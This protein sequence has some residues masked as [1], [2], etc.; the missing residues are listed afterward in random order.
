ME[1][2]DNQFIETI[3]KLRNNFSSIS[4]PRLSSSPSVIASKDHH[5]STNSKI[6]EKRPESIN[7]QSKLKLSTSLLKH[8]SGSLIQKIGLPSIESSKK[9]SDSPKLQ[10]PSNP[11]ARNSSIGIKPPEMPRLAPSTPQI[12][13]NTSQEELAYAVNTLVEI[14]RSTTQDNNEELAEPRKHEPNSYFRE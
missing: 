12:D 11:M 3:K 10:M 13:T 4:G 1:N 8:V 7:L 2:L 14:M 5:L 6:S 9:L